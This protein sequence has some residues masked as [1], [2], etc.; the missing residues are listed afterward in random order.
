MTP[1][2]ELREVMRAKI[3]ET[4]GAD[5][6]PSCQDEQTMDKYYSWLLSQFP[7]PQDKGETLQDS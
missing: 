5:A 3:G 2:T 4:F 6:L 7:L 1:T